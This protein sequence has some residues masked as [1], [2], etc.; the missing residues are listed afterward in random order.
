M[1]SLCNHLIQ[2][3]NMKRASGRIRW[4]SQT[5]FSG[6]ELDSLQTDALSAARFGE[7][8]IASSS[9]YGCTRDEVA[10]LPAKSFWADRRHLTF[11]DRGAVVHRCPGTRTAALTATSASIMSRRKNA[12]AM[13]RFGKKLV[14]KLVPTTP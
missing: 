3:V 10:L 7:V 9:G 14:Y 1:F 2:H 6:I 4:G 11:E 12:K 8:A 5:G 13:V